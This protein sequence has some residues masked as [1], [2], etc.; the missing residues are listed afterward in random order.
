MKLFYDK[1]AIRLVN[2]AGTVL[3]HVEFAKDA[4]GVYDISHTVVDPSLRGQG[5]AG[6]LVRAAADVIRSEGA[7]TRAT[8]SYA[9]S[10][11]A[12]HDDYQDIYK[13]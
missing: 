3:G 6:K 7:T 2:D 12:R 1:N 8:C 4:D 10:W 9:A 5:A 11:L 13:G